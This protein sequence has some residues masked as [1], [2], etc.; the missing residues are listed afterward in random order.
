MKDRD[1]E[2]TRRHYAGLSRDPEAPWGWV[3]WMRRENQQV[4]FATLR[5]IGPLEG[6]HVLDCGCGGGDYYGFLAEHAP[7][8]RYTGW[9]LLE[10]MIATAQERWPEAEFVHRDLLTS[11]EENAFDYVLMSGLFGLKLEDN[12]KL[13]QEALP[14]AF[15][16]CRRG[17]AANMPVDSVDYQEEDMSY[18]SPEAVL[19]LG[20]TLTPWVTLR[21]DY[22]RFDFTVHLYKEDSRAHIRP[23]L[24]SALR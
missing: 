5:E 11:T 4:R 8:T 20:R 10:S 14:R 1:L 2:T 19:R 23:S 17:C 12:W 13:L 22:H 24:L 15:A 6:C 18:F 7:C 3:G 9:D 21:Q 16:L